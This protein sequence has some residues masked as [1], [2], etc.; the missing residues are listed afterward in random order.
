MK[1][2]QEKEQESRPTQ[3]H[4]KEFHRNTKVEVII[5]RT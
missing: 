1:R 2:S 5:Q 3:L 4:K